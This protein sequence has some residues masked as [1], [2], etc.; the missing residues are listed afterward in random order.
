M[1]LY[2]CGCPFDAQPDD[3]THYEPPAVIAYEP[4]RHVTDVIA[5]PAAIAADIAERNRRLAIHGL[6]PA[7]SN[8]T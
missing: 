8:A 2:T 3:C 1:P 6:R 4:F 5:D 7:I